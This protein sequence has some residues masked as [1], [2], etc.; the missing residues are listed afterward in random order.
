MEAPEDANAL[1][2]KLVK[3]AEKLRLEAVNEIDLERE[4]C[5]ARTRVEIVKRYLK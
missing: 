1:R 4:R 3:L 2:E 5:S